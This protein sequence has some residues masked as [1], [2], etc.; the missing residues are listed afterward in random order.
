ML[1]LAHAIGKEKGA[2]GSPQKDTPRRTEEIVRGAFPR[3]LFAFRSEAW[4]AL[5]LALTVA[6]QRWIFATFPERILCRM[7]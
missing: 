5:I 4:L 2:A 3:R 1:K 6:G 7:C